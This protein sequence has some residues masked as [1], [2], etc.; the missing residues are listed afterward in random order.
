MLQGILQPR[1]YSK[2]NLRQALPITAKFKISDTTL[3]T[4]VKYVLLNPILSPNALCT[5]ENYLLLL[6][7]NANTYLYFNFLTP[8]RCSANNPKPAP[9]WPRFGPGLPG[10]AHHAQSSNCA[11]C[12]R[13]H[14]LEEP[15]KITRFRPKILMFGI[16]RRIR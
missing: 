4:I 13:G 14:P 2:T 9:I 8:K 1:H 3:P 12:S 5:I 6:N 7:Y 16:N 10:Q 11:Y 15:L